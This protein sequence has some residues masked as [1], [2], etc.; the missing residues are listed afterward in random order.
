MPIY[1][2]AAIALALHRQGG[3][4]RMLGRIK[5]DQIVTTKSDMQARL[6]DI[7]FGTHSDMVL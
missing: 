7:L 6:A 2:V 4:S 1:T 5:S 3:A